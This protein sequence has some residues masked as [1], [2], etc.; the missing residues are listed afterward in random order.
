[1]H[2]QRIMQVNTRKDREHIGLKKSNQKLQAEQRDGCD[3]RHDAEKPHREDKP[4]N[5]LS[6]V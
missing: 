1:M 3:Q 4:P 6:K 2:V 5:T